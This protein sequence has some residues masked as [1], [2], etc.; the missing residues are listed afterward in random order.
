MADD[1]TAAF[2]RV[3]RD[4]AGFA[5]DM[6]AKGIHVGIGSDPYCVTCGQR[7]PCPA[8]KSEDSDA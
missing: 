8:S 1:L 7:W 3:M 4:L 6:R 2:V 5:E